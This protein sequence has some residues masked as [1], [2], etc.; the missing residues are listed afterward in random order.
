MHQ[1]PTRSSAL[2]GRCALISRPDSTVGGKLTNH[3]YHF[4]LLPGNFPGTRTPRFGG[5]ICL[6]WLQ[7][8]HAFSSFLL[9]CF[10]PTSF[11]TSLHILSDAKTTFSYIH[12][13]ILWQYANVYADNSRS[14][15]LGLS[16]D[17][18]I[19]KSKEYY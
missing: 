19:S 1:T 6:N 15:F 3:S 16:D 7:L 13:C 5:N 10:H 18:L 9:R 2:I 4:Q 12:Y 11:K 17:K 8:F 14:L